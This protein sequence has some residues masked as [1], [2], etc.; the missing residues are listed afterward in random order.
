MAGQLRYSHR[1][2]T[3]VATLALWLALGWPVLLGTLDGRVSTTATLWLVA[4]A[5][6]GAAAFGAMVPKLRPRL[7]WSLLVVQVAAVLALSIIAQWAMMSM[8]LLI[9]AWQAGMATSA[10]RAL[11]WVGV[12]MAAVTVTLALIPEPDI[13]WV[14]GKSLG[15]QLL[16]VLTAHAMRWESKTARALA[17]T[18]RKL[19]SAQAI[20]ARTERDSERLRISRELHDAWG[21]E[22]TALGLQLEIASRATEPGKAGDH[23][24][25]AKALA[26][27]LLAKVRRAVATLREEEA[28]EAPGPTSR[29]PALPAP[30]ARRCEPPKGVRQSSPRPWIATALRASR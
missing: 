29:R 15:L 24:A 25:Q 4:F 23:V 19:R 30:L 27:D 2:I 21:H 12:Q 22:L 5:I 1:W 8:F 26:R 20:L 16:L 6:F 28:L 10:P 17:R 3:C 7:F 18:N 11:T 13:C 14:L 9:T